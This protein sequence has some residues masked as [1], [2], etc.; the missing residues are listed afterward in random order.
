MVACPNTELIQRLKR[1]SAAELGYRIRKKLTAEKI[2]SLLGQNRLSF[3]IPSVTP[4]Y[5]A[6]LEM[7]DLSVKAD[8]D[9]SS[10]LLSGETFRLNAEPVEMKR[11]CDD[12]RHSFSD[13]IKSRPGDPDIRTVWEPA[14]LQNSTLLLFCSQNSCAEGQ[15]GKEAIIE[16]IR[17]NS[18]LRGPHYMSAMECGLRI[19]V[20]FYCLKAGPDLSDEER[21]DLLRAI[22]EHAWWI[23]RNLSLFTSIGNH[24]VC[25]C[26]GL[27][28][29]GALFQSF[30][31]G[32]KWFKTGY[33]LLEQELTHQLL[34]DG[35][36]A[37]Q[38]LSYHRFVL[39]LYWLAVDF[40]ERNKLYD[41]GKWKQRLSQGETFLATFQYDNGLFP[42]IGDS[43]DGYAIARGLQSQKESGQR[44]KDGIKNFLNLATRSFGPRT[45][46]F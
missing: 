22:Y 25:E 41:C 36:P 35:G 14:R 26:M 28:F 31:E 17:S 7:P 32:R 5:I 39:D 6:S 10:R 43:D 46:C 33:R 37:E 38:S 8:G 1:T 12:R 4:A 2:K 34:S 44:P 40:L 18:F 11:F 3:V 42:Y 13:T 30:E 15:A 29:A 16:W 21:N 45:N 24:T 9:L 19:P 23:E 27:I 20:F